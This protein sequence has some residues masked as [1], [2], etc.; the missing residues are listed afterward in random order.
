MTWDLARAYRRAFGSCVHVA[1]GYSVGMLALVAVDSSLPTISLAQESGVEAA[2]S[3][4]RPDGKPVT[5]AQVVQRARENPPAVV[6]ALASLQRF[7]AQEF[8]AKGAYLPRLS[9]GAQAGV[10]YSNYPYLVSTARPPQDIGPPPPVLDPDNP[11]PQEQAATQVYLARFFG[12]QNEAARQ[13]PTFGQEKVS[14][15]SLNAMGNAT[16]DWTVIDFARSG[17]V[18]VA[19]AQRQ[20]Q[21]FAAAASQR[22]AIQS[23]VEL[24]V[25]G[26]SAQTLVD[27]ARLSSDRRNDQLK[28]IAALVRAGVRP[29]VDAQRAEIEAVAARHWLEVRIIEH[30]L[31]MASLAVALGED[32]ANPMRPVP[33]D[34]DPFA[35]PETL[36]QATSLAAENRPEIKQAEAIVAASQADHRSAIG[37]RLPTLGVSGTG[38][39]SYADVKDG[40]GVDGRTVSGNAFAYLRWNAF[41]PMVF[42]RAK[43]T[44]KAVIEAQKQFESSLLQL[45]QKVAE[46]LF[47]AQI[48]KAQLDRATETL[49]AA[50]TT[51]QAQNE[52]YRAGVS[53]LLELLDAEELEQNAR[54]QR[55]EAARDYDLARAQLLAVCGTIDKIR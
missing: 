31:T 18:A 43:V 21:Q 42:R 30:Q 51:R 14:N 36:K 24:F 54:R 25:R 20:Q 9:L 6:A 8:Q 44:S 38:Q 4:A 41:D 39:L 23:A 19:K 40:F 17:N 34:H 15:T 27:D 29:S 53:T 5:L 13:E 55:I 11:T 49:A 33:M 47:S 32:P 10:L 3:V 1:R 35:I 52:R 28:S 22:V 2:T 48:A 46:A 37:A 50:T 45:K 26:L 7:E 12:A 16:V